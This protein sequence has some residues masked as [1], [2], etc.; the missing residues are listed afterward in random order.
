MTLC[1]LLVLVATFCTPAAAQ[2][3]PNARPTELR[4]GDM[5]TLD[6]SGKLAGWVAPKT[7][8]D[9]GYEIGPT[10]EHVFAGK[11]AARIDSR[12][13]KAAGNLFGNLVQSVDAAPWRG[14]RVR[15][16]AAVAVPEG[17]DEGRAQMWLRV[18]RATVDGTPR[19][20]FFDN[21]GDRP[22]TSA[23]WA[24]YEIV[25]DVAEDAQS[26]VLGVLT[27]G[28]CVVLVDDASLEA[29][30]AGVPMTGGADTEPPPEPF[31]TPWLLLP[32]VALALFGLATPSRGRPGRIG[33]FALAFT[34]A[35]WALYSFTELLG[36]LVPFVGAGW[37]AALQS[38]PI[39]SLVRWTARGPLGIHRPLVSAIANGSG[40]TTYSYVQALL[41]FVLALAVASIWAVADRRL[42]ERAR[43]RDVLRSGLRWYLATQMIGYGLAKLG[44]L[45]NQ[46]PPLG[47]WRLAQPY[48][49]SSPMGLLWTFMGSSRA[50]T[51]FAGGMELLGG[52]LLVW[53]RTALLGACVSVGVMLNIMLMNFC[54]DVPVK[55]FSAH[56]VVAGL[57]ILLPDASR[58]ACALVGTGSV[59]PRT[60]DHPHTSRA[61]RWV[62]RG[63]KTAFLV[64]V[65]AMPLYSMWSTERAS[66][67]A[68]PA[69][70]EWKVAAVKIDGEDVAPKTGEV[71]FLTLV[72]RPTPVADT[73]SWTVPCSITLVGGAQVATTATLTPGHV[74]FEPSAASTSAL[75][76]EPL[77]WSVA[78]DE[79][80]L[81]R[82]GMQATLA[83][84]ARDYL[85]ARRGFHWINEHPFNR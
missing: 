77:A 13:V 5:E 49:E 85:L 33:A 59:P 42:P 56:L 57:C 60:I 75:L 30:D 26:I 15:F 83:P 78:E 54:Y 29:V 50:Y 51:A 37:S 12:A 38:G 4:N 45:T 1:G 70:G 39:D 76:R 55:L 65:V 23:E 22:I 66:A 18:D 44:T 41:T 31:F 36:T 27:L 20:G 81:E 16:R 3:D 24:S 74:V 58:L 67:G 64:I 19:P 79:L 43:L 61:T 32:L 53:R 40:D 9:A 72:P 11:R 7:L 73:E 28:Q 17:G 2:T 82:P 63:L 34:I 62:H 47:L 52:L 14:K 80:R 69:L 21:M 71:Q 6:A 68:R 10:E 46:F 84:R 48:G 35:Y 8:L 25:G